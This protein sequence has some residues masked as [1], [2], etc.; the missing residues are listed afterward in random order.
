MRHNRGFALAVFLL[1]M[2]IVAT[3]AWTYL[4]VGSVTRIEA[5]REARSVNELHAAEAGIRFYLTTGETKTFELNGCQVEVAVLDSKVVSTARGGAEQ[6]SVVLEVE[7][8]YVT[9]R[10]TNEES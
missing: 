7:K 3:M 8:G 6:T 2:P 9:R 1:L 5:L 10:L 4:K